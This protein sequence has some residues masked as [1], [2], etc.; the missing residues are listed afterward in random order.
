MTNPAS[1]VHGCDFRELLDENLKEKTTSGC[2]SSLLRRK[3][4]ERDGITFDELF[5]MAQIIEDVAEQK[6]FSVTEKEDISN[7][8]PTKK[9]CKIETRAR[10]NQF[11]K[12]NFKFNSSIECS[13]C[14][15]KGHKAGFDKCPAKGKECKKCG[16][17]DHFA[18][19]CLTREPMKRKHFVDNE[20]N[21]YKY[22]QKGTQFRIS[23]HVGTIPKNIKF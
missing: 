2:K 6:K 13:R 18:R 9:V 15:L 16:K 11:H 12:S 4:L 10:F 7:S 8:N 5:K 17:N 19:K 22:E 3:I 23:S 14:G 20:N 21:T 1:L